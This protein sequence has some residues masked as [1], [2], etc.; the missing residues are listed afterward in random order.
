MN[1][2]RAL[3]PPQVVIDECAK[4]Y[5]ETR[6]MLDLP[7]VRPDHFAFVV[8]QPEFMSQHE[9]FADNFLGRS[10]T[11]RLH[12]TSL[13]VAG[14]VSP[15]I[16]LNWMGQTLPHLALVGSDTMGLKSGGGYIGFV[17]DDI[18]PAVSHII[19]NDMPHCREALY[20]DEAIRID[21]AG[22]D[23]HYDPTANLYRAYIFTADLLRATN[24][25]PRY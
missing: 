8:S 11:K 6:G 5:K 18:H 25:L 15:R 19:F 22:R 14:T 13:I 12:G 1:M 16:K 9:R 10:F 24:H 3:V 7:M 21:L 17:A 2:L 4:H 20:G 23:G